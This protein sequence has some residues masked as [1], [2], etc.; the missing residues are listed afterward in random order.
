MSALQYHMPV[1]NRL[2]CSNPV[3]PEDADFL[4]H[5]DGKKTPCCLKHLSQYERPG[6]RL[7]KLLVAGKYNTEPGQE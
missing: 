3:C 2:L 4:V 7:E 5:H 6:A 1:N